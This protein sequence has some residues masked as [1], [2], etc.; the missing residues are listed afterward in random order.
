L[1]SQAELGNQKTITV[2]LGGIVDFAVGYGTDGS[3]YNDTTG[4]SATITTVPVP[5]TLLLL[6]SGLLGL[7][8]WRRFRKS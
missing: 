2:A 3:Y 8:G 1:G 5:S 7:G 4:L 6:G